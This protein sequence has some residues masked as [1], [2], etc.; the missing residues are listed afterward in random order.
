MGLAPLEAMAFGA[1]PLVSSLACFTDFIT[2][3]TNGV[4]F[5]HRS[6]D[7]IP[8]LASSLL[9][10]TS[11]PLRLYRLSREA[12]LV[13]Q[14]HHPRRIAQQMLECFRDI[15]PSDTNAVL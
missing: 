14:T 6:H 15:C 3:G 2:H 4:M 5:D 10:L 8:A 11:D 13:R 1:V 12:L 9:S 7:S